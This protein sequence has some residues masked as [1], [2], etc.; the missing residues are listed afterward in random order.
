MEAGRVIGGKYRL[1]REIGKG[2]M[3]SVWAAVHESLGRSVAVKFLRPTGV[4]PETAAARF[5]AEARMAAAVKHRFVVDIFDFGITEDGKSYMVLELLEG[6]ELG[7]RMYYGPPLLVSD[8]IRFVGKCL[9]GLEAVHQAGIVHRDLKPENIFIIREAEDIFPTLLDF[10]IS[11]MSGGELSTGVSLRP[12]RMGGARPVRLTMPGTVIGTP[13]YMAPE[14]LRG[15]S[16]I[17]ARAD[18][19]A[20]AVILWEWVTG[21]VPYDHDNI[22][23]LYMNMVRGGPP[24]LYS[25]RPDLGRGLSEVLSK[26]MATRPGDRFQNAREM[27]LALMASVD[28]VP[29]AWTVVQKSI[30]NMSSAEVLGVKFPSDPQGLTTVPPAP[31]AASPLPPAF[32]SPHPTASGR[33]VP[34]SS[35]PAEQPHPPSKGGLSLLASMQ[36]LRQAATRGLRWL[37]GLRWIQ[38]WAARTP[39][40]AAWA[41]PTSLFERLTGSGRHLWASTWLGV[42]LLVV[43]GTFSGDGRSSGTHQPSRHEPLLTTAAAQPGSPPESGVLAAEREAPADP[44]LASWPEAGAEIWPPPARFDMAPPS[45]SALE[46]HAQSGAAVATPVGATPAEQGDGEAEVASDTSQ[47]ASHRRIK[48]K[49]PRRPKLIRSLDF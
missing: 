11:K 44:A 9:S 20:M 32:P 18:I 38:A 28:A 41:S 43:V 3:G 8:A 27:R 34:D 35:A 37:R 19:F 45:M 15:L 26:A 36:D 30:A 21:R 46:S 48:R 25:V 4:N 29:Q 10:G 17:D 7:E 6:E 40:V 49:V 16:S 33:P 1:R 5:V 2:A 31:F 13:W 14:Q 12:P 23:D 39:A 42:L 47:G 24:D 22:G